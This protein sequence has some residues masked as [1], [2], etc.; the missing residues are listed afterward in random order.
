[1]Q[2]I[3][4]TILN[5]EET[6]N[7]KGDCEAQNFV[8]TKD[9]YQGVLALLQQSQIFPTPHISNQ[10]TVCSNTPSTHTPYNGKTAFSTTSWVL[11]SGT[12]DHIC[13]SLSCFSSYHHIKPISVKLPNGATVF[14][15]F[16]GSVPLTQHHIL[17][18]VLYI[19][20]FSFNLI[21]IS[22]LTE[23]LSCVLCFDSKLCSIEEKST[24]RM[25]GSAEAF[26]GLYILRVPHFTALSCTKPISNHINVVDLV[27]VLAANVWHFRLGHASNSCLESIQ[28]KISFVKGNK[29]Y[30]CDVCHLAKQK[31]L[32]SPVSTTKSNECFDLIHIDI[33]GPYST[34][35]VHG[36]KYFLTV[37]DDHSRYTWIYLMKSKAEAS[38]ILHIFVSL[39]QT[40]FDKRVKT[41]RSD[42]G[43]EFIMTDFYASKGI[44][45]QTTCVH[46]PQ[47]NSIVERKH[48]HL[49]NVARALM[50]QS[51]L[52]KIYWSYAVLHAA[53][54]IN[55]LP[56][57]I[58]NAC[59]P[60]ERLYKVLP[61]FSKLKVFGSLCF[62]STSK[63][64]RTQ[65]DH[66]AS[67]CIFLG[68]KV[69]T[70]GFILL[71][72]GTRE[73]FV[74]RDVIFYENIFPYSNHSLD[75]SNNSNHSIIL[76]HDEPFTSS[77]DIVPL[78]INTKLHPQSTTTPHNNST[79]D[80][81]EP[82]QP[83]SPNANMSNEP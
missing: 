63:V 14:A 40:Q 26:N 2:L 54:I 35:S 82:T 76:P 77:D 39:I 11:D 62:A 21:S 55:I 66:R 27:N 5:Q 59:S 19:P 61:N 80:D 46:T 69:G 8:L 17:S 24:S 36:H 67:K 25:I 74:S 13:F 41:I 47:Q 4:D 45:H 48:G 37:I 32:P 30:I 51:N 12:T 70:K 50:I 34:P 49:L 58:L 57:P 16:S 56:T 75:T 1:M 78:A 33:W 3:G 64:N 81:A 10:V 28:N 9:Q 38:K 68:Y 71:N 43:S 52:P 22:K 6:E 20:S 83:D 7:L 31:H 44:I 23:S 15:H 73:L 53:Y 60:H 18:N 72:I 29:S 42:N 65:F 79:N